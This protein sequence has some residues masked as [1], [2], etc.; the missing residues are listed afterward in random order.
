MRLSIR[1][2]FASYVACSAVMGFSVH[3]DTS[4]IED[5]SLGDVSLEVY[6]SIIKDSSF[7]RFKEMDCKVIGR[8]I[9]KVGSGVLVFATTESACG[10]G[11]S[12]GPIW[13]ILTEDGKS[14]LVL[15]SGGYGVSAAKICNADRVVISSSLG[16]RAVFKRFLY[17]GGKYVPAPYVKAGCDP[18]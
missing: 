16:G 8:S 3:A 11:A 12:I 13:L 17:H 15:S 2:F 18:R 7:S 4:A 1:I 10:W 9:S 14:K 5:T 6:N